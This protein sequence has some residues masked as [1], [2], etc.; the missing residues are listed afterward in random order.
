M[1]Q[2]WC[3]LIVVLG[4]GGGL[5]CGAS[6]GV[7]EELRRFPIASLDDVLTKSGVSIDGEVTADGNGSLRIDAEAPTT[8]RL[9]ELDDIDVEDARLTYRARIRTDGAEG[10]VY[11]EMWCG[12]RGMGEFFSRGLHAPLTGSVEW[13]TQEIPFFL[14]P[15]QN[16]DTVKLNV[17]LEGKGTVWIDDVVLLKGPA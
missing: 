17:V 2:W 5:G 8:V 7:P 11:L 15:G 6:Q 3:S 12:L 9:F 13:T 1:R 4:F 14:Q 10:R 16:P